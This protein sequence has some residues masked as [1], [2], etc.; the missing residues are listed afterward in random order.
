MDSMMW[1]F[2]AGNTASTPSS[3]AYKGLKV[4]RLVH[5][6]NRGQPMT[7][8]EHACAY[9]MLTAEGKF[10]VMVRTKKGVRGFYSPEG[11]FDSMSEAEAAGVALY[12][13]Q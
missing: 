10:G 6:D 9:I 7:D 3:S 2:P 11:E 1:I 4:R 5:V 8:Q 13:L 12:R